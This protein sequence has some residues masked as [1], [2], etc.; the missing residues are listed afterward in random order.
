MALSAFGKE[1]IVVKKKKLSFPISEAFEQS[2]DNY[3]Q[4]HN[5]GDILED[6]YK[7]ELQSD[8]NCA[9]NIEINDEQAEEL[10]DYYLR[11]G[12]YENI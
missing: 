4:A 2:I 1:I 9:L 8:I 10:R 7:A 12:M 6:C 11:G 3:I 5:R